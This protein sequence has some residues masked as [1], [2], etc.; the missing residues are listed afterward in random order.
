MR[1]FHISFC[2]HIYYNKYFDNFQIKKAS[3]CLA[4]TYWRAHLHAVPQVYFF[5]QAMVDI[6]L[7]PVLR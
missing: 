6:H 1:A 7:V 2:L 3:H 5:A 4:E